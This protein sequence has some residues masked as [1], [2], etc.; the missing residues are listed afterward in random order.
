MDAVE[1]E[2]IY[3]AKI[4]LQSSTTWSKFISSFNSHSSCIH[5]VSQQSPVRYRETTLWISNWRKCF[6][7]AHLQTVKKGGSNYKEWS[8]Y[9]QSECRGSYS[10]GQRRKNES[11]ITSSLQPTDASGAHFS[12]TLH[13]LLLWLRSNPRI[14]VLRGSNK[15][16][17]QSSSPCNPDQR[18]GGKAE[19]EWGLVQEDNIWHIML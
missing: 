17:P 7:E 2:L 15:R 16:S 1:K 13:L 9:Q 12:S 4:S 6:I 3:I 14:H 11:G 18:W 8:C 19:W 10:R 5:Y